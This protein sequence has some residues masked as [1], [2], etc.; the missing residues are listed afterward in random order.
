MKL[1]DK[2]AIVTGAGSGF[3]QAIALELAKE[4]ANVT[5][6]DFDE[7]S[8]RKTAE[9]IQKI[10]RKAF[11]LKVDV[12]SNSEVENMAQKTL[13]KFGKIDI[14]VNSA[15]AAT[16]NEVVNLKEEEWD[17]VIDVNVKGTFLCSRAVAKQMIK[18]GKGGKIVNLSSIAGNGGAGQ[19]AHYAASKGALITFTQCLSLELTSHRINVNAVCP[20]IVDSSELKRGSELLGIPSEE[21]EKEYISFSLQSEI[22]KPEDVAK[23]VVFLASNESD[24]MT[25]QAIDVSD[26]ELTMNG[27]ITVPKI[28]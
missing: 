19:L 28:L 11:T 7:E 12:R 14:L 16:V 15:S 18:Q 2:I 17:N 3:G 21:I 6:A 5:V 27:A 26:D 13:E 25:G 23:L 9:E 10:G 1:S 4:G 20:G 24:F 22:G 8:V